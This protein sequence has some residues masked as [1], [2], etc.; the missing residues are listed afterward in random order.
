MQGHPYCS[1]GIEVS[2]SRCCRSVCVQS[3]APDNRLPQA[4]R[5]FLQLLDHGEKEVKSAQLPGPQSMSVT[6]LNK[7]GLGLWSA[8]QT[9]P[10]KEGNQASLTSWDGY[11]APFC[12][13]PG[14]SM[15]DRHNM[16][17]SQNHFP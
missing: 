10:I 17:G 9:K 2:G 13:L 15:S 8:P 5:A 16:R 14:K 3:E 7:Q 6:D 11:V 4:P 12:K 1:G